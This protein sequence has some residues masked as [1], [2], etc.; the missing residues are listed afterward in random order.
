MTSG[1][2]RHVDDLEAH[3]CYNACI[4][5]HGLLMRYYVPDIHFATELPAQT[6]FEDKL[7]GMPWGIS[8]TVWPLCKDCGKSQSLLAQFAHHTKRLDLGREGR[9]LNVFQ[10]N[11]DPGVCSTW[12][13]GSGANACFVLEP[14]QMGSSLS[15]RP[16]DEPTIERE[17]RVVKWLERE[18]GIDAETAAKF[19]SE[20]E[21]DKLSTEVHGKVPMGT[22]LRG[23]PEWVQSPEEAPKDGWTFV[24]QLDSGY[25]FY[26]MPAGWEA[27]NSFRNPG[28][29]GRVAYEMG[30]NFGDMG[31]AYLFL[32][33]TASVPEGWFFW[34]CN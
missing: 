6:Q 22:R 5:S 33:P 10:C 12:E 2:G 20:S 30:Y 27:N 31:A 26:T 4:Q 17:A 24:G 13:G 14:E 25:H 29:D 11:H 7:G 32:R 16:A 1:L 34:Q 21:H 8:A 19:F 18:D 23:V 3:L 28:S 15:V 9:T